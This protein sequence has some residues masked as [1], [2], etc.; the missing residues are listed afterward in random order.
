MGGSEDGDGKGAKG[1][2]VTGMIDGPGSVSTLVLVVVRSTAEGGGTLLLPEED[3][4]DVGV[5]EDDKDSG[6]RVDGGRDKGACTDNDSDVL[7]SVNGKEDGGTAETRAAAARR[8]RMT[9]AHMDV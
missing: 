3:I 8:T 4:L 6:E 2:G 7:G 9:E 5:R 1:Y